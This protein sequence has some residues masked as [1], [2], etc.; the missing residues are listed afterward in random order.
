MTGDLFAG[1]PDVGPQRIELADGAVLMRGFAQNIDHTLLI[2][3]R[4]VIARAPLR[5]LITPGGYRMSVSMTCCGSFGWVSEQSGY[6]YH[7]IDPESGQ[8]WP[9]MPG[10]FVS[11]ARHAA[12]EAGFDDFMPDACLINCYEPGARLSLHQDRHE[13][14]IAAP[15]VSVSLGLPAIF[16]FGGMQRND[17]TQR[18]RLAHGDVAV[19]GGPARFA[20]HGI[21]PLEDGH[22]PMLGRKRIN[23]TFR[24]VR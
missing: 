11:L 18:Y 10:I 15:I 14:D 16:L 24:K 4:E 6:R 21:A 22:H 3:A 23:I 20:F 8:P 5:H 7:P 1:L 13:R 19:W 17:R 2:A 9:P 12:A